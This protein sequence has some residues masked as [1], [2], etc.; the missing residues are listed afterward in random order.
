MPSVL[1]ARILEAHANVA[2]PIRM[3]TICNL[4]IQ[5]LV[6]QIDPEQVGI[7]ASIMQ[8]LSPSND[9]QKVHNLRVQFQEKSPAM[10]DVAD[11]SYFL[12][13]ESLVGQTVVNC[14][15]AVIQDLHHNAA[16]LVVH[17]VEKMNS[18]AAYPLQKGGRVAG[19]LLILSTQKQ[20]FS[21]ARQALIQSYAHLLN[22]AFRDN[23][24]YPLEDI[25]LQIMPS[26]AVQ[27]AYL[28]AFNQQVN[29]LLSRAERNGH[30]LARPQAEQMAIEIFI[31]S[32]KK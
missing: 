18:A 28:L 5:Q 4:V 7:V 27:D 2:E 30:S 31:E 6:R 25:A 26:E 29:E 11:R 17:Q 32:M 19:G 9:D 1:Y 16:P 3:W 10:K 24:F 13:A 8:C 20:Y 12:G 23:E 15:P 21:P 22:L 14:R